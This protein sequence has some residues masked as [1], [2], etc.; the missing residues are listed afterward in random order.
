MYLV[1]MVPVDDTVGVVHSNWQKENQRVEWPKSKAF[2]DYQRM[3][4][5]GLYITDPVTM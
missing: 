4:L 2:A 3:L 1:V 5:N